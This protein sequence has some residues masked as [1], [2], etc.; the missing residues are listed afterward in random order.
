M[1]ALAE[2]FS[3]GEGL[4]VIELA[5][6]IKDL[7]TE[8]EAAIVAGDGAALRFELGP[9][10]LEASIAVEQSATAGSKLKFFLV[11]ANADGKAAR[12]NTQK[13]KL[14]L[15]PSLAPGGGSPYVSGTPMPFEQ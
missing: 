13:V 15:T 8:L 12:T 4:V 2:R 6:V 9:I 3:R 14:V 11:E 5:T 7:R 1:Q 10:E